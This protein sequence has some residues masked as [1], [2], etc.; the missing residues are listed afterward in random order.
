MPVKETL[1]SFKTFTH[2][3]TEVE[4]HPILADIAVPKSLLDEGPQS[5]T[6]KT[7]RPVLVR[8]HGG[9]LV[10]ISRSFNSGNTDLVFIPLP[11]HL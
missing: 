4:G 3:Y 1:E 5:E 2:A 6:W 7:K 11:T 8:N 9:F 10:G